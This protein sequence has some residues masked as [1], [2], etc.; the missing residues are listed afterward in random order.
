MKINPIDNTNFKSKIKVTPFLQDGINLT[1]NSIKRSEMKSLDF[2]KKF[3]ESLNIISE[4][5]KAKVVSFDIDKAA[6][7]AAA[8]ADGKK[9]ISYPIQDNIQP[10]Y[11]ATQIVNKY[12]DSIN[13]E[14]IPTLLDKYKL[15]VEIAKDAYKR[16]HECYQVSIEATFEDCIKNI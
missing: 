1:R 9:A 2:A 5:D 4:S 10:A 6:N 13:D 15:N 11:I 3:V 12:A 16:A 8:Y 7:E 14:P